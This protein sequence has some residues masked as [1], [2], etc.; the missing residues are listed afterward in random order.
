MNQAFINPLVHTSI[1][2]LIFFETH[3][4][5]KF[6][7]KTKYLPPPKYSLH[8]EVK[9][10]ETLLLKPVFFMRDLEFSNEMTFHNYS[11]A[12]GIAWNDLHTGKTNTIL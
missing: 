1:I 12:D 7:N 2:Y 11:A 6:I 9:E 10:M 3:I 8:I 4:I 5:A